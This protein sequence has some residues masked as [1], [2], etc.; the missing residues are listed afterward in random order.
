MLDPDS[1]WYQDSITNLVVKE[2]PPRKDDHQSARKENDTL[3]A[4]LEAA[5][6]EIVDLKNDALK[7]NQLEQ[8]QYLSFTRFEKEK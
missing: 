6:R 3:T 7:Q 1:F 4:E 5:N 8:K 2:N